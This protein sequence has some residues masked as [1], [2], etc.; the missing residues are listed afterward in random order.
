MAA[1]V[2][3][4]LNARRHRDEDQVAMGAL[5]VAWVLCSTP[6]GI[7][8][9]ISRGIADDR[10]DFVVLNA[11]RHRDEDQV[12]DLALALLE[13]LVLNARRHRD[14]DQAGMAGINRVRF[15]ACSTP[16]GIETKI[17]T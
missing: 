2:T 1:S 13:L 11:R 12:L 8:T 15:L 6:E 3:V 5:S 10:A 17:R 16:E 7:E 14:E 9:K 4:V